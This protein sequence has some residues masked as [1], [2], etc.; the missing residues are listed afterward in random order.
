MRQVDKRSEESLR[1]A[2]ANLYHD[3][4]IDCA[5]RLGAVKPVYVFLGHEG[6]GKTLPGVKLFEFDPCVPGCSKAPHDD[7]C[8]IL[9][10]DAV[11]EAE[12]LRPRLAKIKAKI[13]PLDT[14]PYIL[15]IDIDAFSTRKA[16][17]PTDPS[18]FKRLARHASI[19][20]VARERDCF[21]DCRLEDDFS[22]EEAESALLTLLEQH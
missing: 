5:M 20:T 1:R 16:L 8:N 12:I 11:I 10:A 19:I 3:E 6:M 9:Q 15:D 13:G 17:S 22:F 7:D 21:A 18:E 4:H 14:L 2:V